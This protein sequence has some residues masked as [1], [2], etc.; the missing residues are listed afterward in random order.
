[1]A[2]LSLTRGSWLFCRSFMRATLAPLLVVLAAGCWTAGYEREK[3]RSVER[4][5][6]P[7]DQTLEPA[8]TAAVTDSGRRLV[9]V[10]NRLGKALG[11]FPVDSVVVRR[12]AIRGGSPEGSETI[13]EGGRAAVPVEN[14]GSVKALSLGWGPTP[15]TPPPTQPASAGIG[16]VPANAEMYRLSANGRFLL[17]LQLRGAAVNV[18]GETG[19]FWLLEYFDVSEAR[20]PRRIGPALEIDGTLH[21]AA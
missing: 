11:P 3:L 16:Q 17:V 13:I 6:V 19:S 12:F 9:V 8:W 4:I 5:P 2:R 21:N 18:R 10:A 1:M 15:S 14:G 7:N 20:E